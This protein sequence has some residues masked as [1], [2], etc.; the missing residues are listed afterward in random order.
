ML[1]DLL[2]E[3]N[4]LTAEIKSLSQDLEAL[5]KQQPRYQALLAIPGIMVPGL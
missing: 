3:I 2:T 4:T 1:H 5:C